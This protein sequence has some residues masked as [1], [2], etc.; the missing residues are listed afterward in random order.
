MEHCEL[1]FNKDFPY[2]L[3]QDMIYMIRVKRSKRNQSKISRVK[4]DNFDI[5]E[6]ENSRLIFLTKMFYRQFCF[7][8]YEG[9]DIFFFSYKCINEE[10]YD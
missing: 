8:K 9:K 5:V 6:M 1:N 7:W 4:F 2:F 3:F 10:K